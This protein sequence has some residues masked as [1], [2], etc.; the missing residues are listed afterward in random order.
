MVIAPANTG[1][2]NNNR[3]A[4]T[5]TDQTNNGT[6]FHVIPRARILQ[7]VTIK[8]IAPAILLIPAM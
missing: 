3:I 4:V 6:R 8:L 2:D 7:I 5:K 1:R